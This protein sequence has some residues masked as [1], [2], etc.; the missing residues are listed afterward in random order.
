MYDFIS[1]QEI[2]HFNPRFKISDWKT[3]LRSR[4]KAYGKDSILVAKPG[5]NC[6]VLAVELPILCNYPRD[7]AGRYLPR[8][9][10]GSK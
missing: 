10:K 5:V 9:D 7:K 1:T 3:Y 2:I 4:E 8:L 6:T